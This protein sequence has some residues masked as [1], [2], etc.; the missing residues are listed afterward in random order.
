MLGLRSFMFERV[1]LGP[2]AESERSRATEPCGASSKISSSTLT[3]CRTIDR[4]TSS[5]GS[6]IMS[7]E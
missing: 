7:P 3:S 4:A 5:T 6:R 2:A 1:Y